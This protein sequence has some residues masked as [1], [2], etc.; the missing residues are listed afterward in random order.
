MRFLGFRLSSCLTLHLTSQFIKRVLCLKSGG[1]VKR[2]SEKNWKMMRPDPKDGRSLH[3]L[4][5]RTTIIIFCHVG[6]ACSDSTPATCASPPNPE[7]THDGR[8]KLLNMLLLR[9]RSLRLSRCCQF[10]EIRSEGWTSH[11]SLTSNPYRQADEDQ[12]TLKTTR[13]RPVQDLPLRLSGLY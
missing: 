11:R 13:R 2:E 3:G 9:L 4:T 1:N 12:R 6:W 7:D 5:A 8:L 10:H